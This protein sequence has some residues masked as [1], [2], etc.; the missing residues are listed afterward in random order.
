[1]KAYP[2]YKDS[3]INWLGMLPVSWNIKKVKHVTTCLDGKRIP[4]NS[5]E[6]SEIPGDFPYWGANGIVDY[7]NDYLFDEDLVLLG[8]D[9][10]PFFEDYKPVAFSVRG[11]IWVNNHIHVLK[12]KGINSNYLTYCLNITD[13]S[14]FISGSTRDKL[15]Q[16][17]MSEIQLP[18]PTAEEQEAV[19]TYLDDATSRI[20]ALI[21]KKE[22]MIELLKEKR[23]ALITHAVTKGLDPN[24]KMKD[25]GIEWLG[26]VPEHWEIKMVKHVAEFYTGWTPPSGKDEYYDGEYPWVNISDLGNKYLY[27]PRRTITEEAINDFNIKLSKKG[28]LLF[29]FKLS[30]GLVSILKNDMFTNEAIA[31]FPRNNKIDINYLYYLAPIAIPMNAGINIYNAPM[32]NQSSINNAALAYPS[33]EE[34][35]AIAAYLD[36]ATSRIDALIEKKEQMIELLSEYRSSLIHHAVTGKID[37]RGYH[38]KTQ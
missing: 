22:Q 34:Q 26:N 31:T 25:S 19:V 20:D 24:V 11:K 9:G 21:E 36:D 5:L 3:G 32:L 18:F 12:P 13:Y 38:A 23:I 16:N 27:Q 8:E 30:I 35:Q 4:L 6:R 33:K 29:S 28:S 2:K 17:D 1:M 10:A 15:T 7:I 37:L 14:Y